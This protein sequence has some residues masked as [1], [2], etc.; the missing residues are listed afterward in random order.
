[1]RWTE[2]LWGTSRQTEKGDFRHR[3]RPSATV[4]REQTVDLQPAPA[5][6]GQ[7]GSL[8]AAVDTLGLPIEGQITPADTQDRNALA[9]VLREVRRKSPFVTM[10]FTDSGYT[11]DE[12]QRAAFEARRISVTVVRRNDK[13]VQGFIALPKRWVVERTFGWINRARRTPSPQY[14]SWRLRQTRGGSDCDPCHIR[15]GRN[16]QIFNCDSVTLPA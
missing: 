8:H 16:M 2:A 10:G 1:M 6:R 13:Q 14:A 9:P 3:I 12:A 15:A 4:I 5:R 7:H 11:G